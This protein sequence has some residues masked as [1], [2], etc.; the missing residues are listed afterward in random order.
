MTMIKT[1]LA[2]L[3]S[4]VIFI[5]F[6]QAEGQSLTASQ[7]RIVNDASLELVNNYER[8]SRFTTDNQSIN[9][10]YIS[11]F[12][13]LFDNDASLYNDILPSNKVSDPVN[14]SQYISIFKNN[15]PYGA[16]VRLNNVLF[17]LPENLGNGRYKMNAELSK[18]IY[19]YTNYNVYYKDTIPLTFVLGFSISGND[20]SDIRILGISGE[21]RGR[22]LK[23][24][25]LKFLT[26]K[27]WADAEI[28][29]DSKIERTNNQGI[30]KISNIDPWKEH[31]LSVACDPYKPVILSNIDIDELIEANTIRRHQILKLPYYDQNELIFFTNILDLTIAPVVSVGFPGMKTI[32]SEGQSDELEFENLRESGRFSPRIGIRFGITLLRTSNFDLSF[33]TGFE[34]NFIRAAYMFDTCR[35]ET[36]A[37]HQLTVTD[38]YDHEQKI[39]LNFTDVPLLISVDYKGFRKFDV[40]TDFGISFTR[41]NKSTCSIK[42]GYAINGFYEDS[43]TLTAEYHD[44]H[45]EDR[46]LSYQL[47][48]TI[49]KEILPSLKIFCGPKV[50]FFKSNWLENEE[51]S[52]NLLSSDKQINNILNTYKSSKIK[53]AALEFGIKYNF[54]SIKLK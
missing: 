34:K 12:R 2:I 10:N 33:N 43:D 18:E 7:L 31:N 40:G 41:L 25:I 51:A 42:S 50:F 21:P 47:G 5:P 35:I 39:T 19:G 23:L 46:F 29:I 54:N 4:T 49:S 28:R 8:Y 53:Y 16:G 52:G 11:L 48:L 6:N 38:I 14:L 36:L 22:F 26:L 3:F 17:D 27:P 13:D 30:A 15:F 45:S 9:E 1:S 37:D 24:R 20:I 32:L 44:F